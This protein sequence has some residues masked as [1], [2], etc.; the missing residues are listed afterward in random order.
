[1]SKAPHLAVVFEDELVPSVIVEGWPAATPLPRIVMV[2]YDM[3]TPM[4]NI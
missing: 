3:E 4:A 1:M 2:N